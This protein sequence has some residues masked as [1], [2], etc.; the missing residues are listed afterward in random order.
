VLVSQGLG[1]PEMG[2]LTGSDGHELRQLVPAAA[3][4]EVSFY[5]VPPAPE[6]AVSADTSLPARALEEDRRL[7]EW[8]LESLAVEAHGAFVREVSERAFERVL[9]ETTGYYR[10]GFEPQ[11][12]DRDGKARKVEVK[13]TRPGLVV[14]AR[15]LASPRS[16]AIVGW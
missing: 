12:N 11:G 13:V 6:A 9:R 3:T 1:F 7:H 10:L 5:V 4:S 15:P 16:S 14:R 8:G 2:A